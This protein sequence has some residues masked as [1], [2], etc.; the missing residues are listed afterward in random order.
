L[1]AW[2]N[3]L[4]DLIVEASPLRRFM[5]ALL[6]GLPLAA[7][8]AAYLW[9]SP[10]PYRVLYAQL[11]DRAGGEIISALEQLDIPYRLS[12]EDGRI[13][14]PA[15]QLH[16]ARYRLAARGLP[17]SDADAQD[18]AERAPRFGASS[19]QEQQRYQ[20]AQETE[21]ARSIQ[22]L[23]AVELARVHLALPKVSPFLRDAPPATAAVLVRLRPG[24]QL[25][26]EQVTTIQTLVAASVPRMKRADVQVLDP[27]GLVLGGAQPEVAPSQRA[28]LEQ[29]LAQRVLAVLTPWL[30]KER[31]SV[32][33]TATLDDSETRQTVEQVRSVVAGDQ[34][35]PLE[36]TVRTT[37]GPEGRIQRLNAIVILGFEASAAE[38]KR[39]GQLAHSALGLQAARGDRLSVY[40]LP[41]AVAVESAAA[42][43]AAPVSIPALADPSP[44]IT[45]Q[46]IQQVQP[47]SAPS[48]PANDASDWPLWWP[49]L[50]VAGVLLLGGS[51][52]RQ[53]RN[54]PLEAAGQPDDFDAEL[55]AARSQVLADP[56]VTADVIRL[57]MRA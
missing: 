39:A 28:L 40:A 42:P 19:L 54:R 18:E 16:A 12:P 52:W 22:T 53:R 7:L 34:L 25:S 44:S 1:P 38:L 11:S 33:V 47:Q 17:K 2:L 5:F 8:A 21:L 23:N 24:A 10:T 14:V 26:T 43:A 57:W 27:R 48:G 51:W 15:D 55:E 30:G 37:R 9:L 45:P 20:R 31:V 36:K 50:A 3:S 4:R 56:R 29:D 6:L 35:R 46:T 13:E 49:A 32:Q 41:A